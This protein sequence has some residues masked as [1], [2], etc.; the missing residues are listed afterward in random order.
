MHDNSSPQEKY[1]HHYAMY[2]HIEDISPVDSLTVSDI[3]SSGI[4]ELF[5]AH[6]LADLISRKSG[7]IIELIPGDSQAN[8]QR[9]ANIINTINSTATKFSEMTGVKNCFSDLTFNISDTH[10]EIHT[11]SVDES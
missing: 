8:A 3:E 7:I 2:C 6:G 5:T 10:L 11:T 1:E 9:I 4:N